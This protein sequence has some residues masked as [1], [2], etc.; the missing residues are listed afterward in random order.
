MARKFVRSR[1]GRLE[2][3]SVA[4]TLKGPPLTS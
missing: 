3:V 1:T 2:F 4:Q